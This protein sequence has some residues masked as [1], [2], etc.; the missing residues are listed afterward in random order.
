MKPESIKIDIVV[1]H[2]GDIKALADSFNTLT[3]SRA[4]HLV[5]KII[6]VENGPKTG[7]KEFC[8]NIVNVNVEYIYSKTP[9]LSSARN[10]G[11]ERSDADFLIFFDNDLKYTKNTLYSYATAFCKYGQKFFYGGPVE[12]VYEE[13]PQ[14]SMLAYVPPSVKGFS[15]G[16]VDLTSDDAVFLGGNHALSREAISACFKNYQAVYEGE[17]ATGTNGGGVGEEHRLQHRLVQ[18][19]FK[20]CYVADAKVF[21]PVPRECLT[22]EW[23]CNRRF[24]RGLTDASKHEMFKSRVVI[25][26]T[27]AWVYTRF[28]KSA[29]LEKLLLKVNPRIAL[30]HG[31]IRAWC[32][33]VI[34][35]RSEQGGN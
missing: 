12:P 16:D 20:S 23:V 6:L 28:V 33:G 9:G 13:A 8:K 1:P 10:L 18:L 2:Y 11:I 4:I 3:S 27:P 22:H 30:K 5:N 29:L 19:G 26:N 35:A 34:S 24:R 14:D 21:H 31:V 25:R 32:Q 17:S 7:A 15:L